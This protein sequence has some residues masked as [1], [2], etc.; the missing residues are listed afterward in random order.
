MRQ[1]ELLAQSEIKLLHAQVNPHFLFNALNT[2]SSSD[3]PRPR[4]SRQP[5]LNLSTF[6]SQQSQAPSEEACPVKRSHTS[7]PISKSSGARQPWPVGGRIRYP[8]D[9]RL[10]RMPAFFLCNPSWRTRSSTVPLNCSA[11]VISGSRPRARNDMMLLSV[12]DNA[13]L[14]VEPATSSGLG[15]HHLVR[16]RIAARH[17]SAFGLDIARTRGLLPGSCSSCH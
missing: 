4:A 16:R 12:E 1:R 2:L 5:G 9:R 3:S 6:F 10:V 11:L 8:D 7:R 14:Y 13:G 17:G 15:M